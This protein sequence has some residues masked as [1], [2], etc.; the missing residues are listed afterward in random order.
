[1]PNRDTRGKSASSAIR[2][3]YTGG[4]QMLE[5]AYR[6]D[7]YFIGHAGSLI[8]S[9]WSAPSSL[10]SLD[11]LDRMHIDMLRRYPGGFSLLTVMRDVEAPP[12]EVR[13]AGS[14]MA[15][16][17]KNNV[18]GRAFLLRGHG[19]RIATMRMV[20]TSILFFDRVPSHVA[21][22]LEAALRWLCKLP[23]QRSDFARFVPEAS[24]A[25]HAAIDVAPFARS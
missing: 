16:R 13:K 19:L 17:H 9:A 20:L 23:R 14:E 8:V 10:A 12:E 3:G 5:I 4:P 21:S 2:I 11:E 18:I 22:E 24:P 25:I 7:T 15:K 1:M 6:S